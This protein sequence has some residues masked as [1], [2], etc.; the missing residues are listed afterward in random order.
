MSKPLNNILQW[1]LRGL[2]GKTTE[3]QCLIS[4]YYPEVMALQETKLPPNEKFPIF[5]T[6]KYIIHQKNRTAYGGGV[7]LM[8]HEDVSHS[9]I[10]IATNLEAVA[11]II[12]Y[13]SQNIAICSIYLP[14]DDPFPEND[15]KTLTA[16]LPQSFLI[17]GDT[18]TKHPLWG[19]PSSDENS[20]NT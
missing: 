7:A 8:I 10:N 15:F 3:L 6:K 17:L 9:L 14:P 18:N 5:L 13:H 20:S 11:A 12:Y 16:S 4:K 1:N 19:S 2:R